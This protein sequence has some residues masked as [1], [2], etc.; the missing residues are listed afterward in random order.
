MLHN[1]NTPFTKIGFEQWHRDGATMAVIAVRG[2]YEFV[3][4]G[5]LK[6]CDTQEIVLADAF[7]GDPQKTPLLRVGDLIPFKPGTDVTFLGS[8]FAPQGQPAATWD[9]AIRAHDLQ[10]T[11]RVCGARNWIAD[12]DGFGVRK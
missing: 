1:N 11:L 5:R 4:G 7:D 9:A 12:G 3:A 6:L 8:A 10:Q 2:D